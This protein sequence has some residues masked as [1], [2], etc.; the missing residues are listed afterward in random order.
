MFAACGVSPRQT[1]RAAAS[2]APATSADAS[3]MP[4]K[5]GLSGVPSPYRPLARP[6]RPAWRTASTYAASCTSSSSVISAGTGTVTVT[7]G[8]SSRPNSRASAIVSS[9]RTG[10]SGCPG[11]KSYP[12]RRSSQTRVSGQPTNPPPLIGTEFPAPVAGGL[13]RGQE[14][15]PHPVLLQ[16]PD[17][18]DRGPPGR[19]DGL[20]QDHRVLPGLAEHGG[21]AVDRLDDHLQRGAT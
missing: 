12:V 19:G 2:V 1:A 15:G 14:R 18:R 3:C 6:S 20:A 21:R 13:D 5:T 16:L 7:S 10:A 8:R 11:P 17:R 9:T 4:A